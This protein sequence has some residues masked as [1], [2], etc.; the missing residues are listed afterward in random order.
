M[1]DPVLTAV[2]SGKNKVLLSWTFDSNADFQVYQKSN[3]PAGQ[4][5]ALLTTTNNFSFTTGDLYN[6]KSYK[7]YVKANVGENSYSS[8]IVELIVSCD[9]LSIIVT[10]YNTSNMDVGRSEVVCFRDYDRGILIALPTLVIGC[11]ITVSGFT[12]DANNGVFE[13]WSIYTDPEM[14]LIWV[15]EHNDLVIEA[16]GNPITVMVNP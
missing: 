15:R 16:A 11:F 14:I 7:F 13:V 4:E 2:L 10:G 5:Y 1:A 8:N 3:N 6:N 12:N 9:K